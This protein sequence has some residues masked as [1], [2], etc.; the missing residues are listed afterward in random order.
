M[1]FVY[2]Y[3]DDGCLVCFS[4]GYGAGNGID[5]WQAGREVGIY[6][7]LGMGCGWGWK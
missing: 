3:D 2:V 6:G 1:G 7:A 4:C 5:F